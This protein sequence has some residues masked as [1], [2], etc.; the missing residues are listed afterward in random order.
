ME[1]LGVIAVLVVIATPVMLIILLS[2]VGSIR[3]ELQLLKSTVTGAGARR[4]EQRDRSARAAHLGEWTAAP[5]AEDHVTPE[6]LIAPKTSLLPPPLPGGASTAMEIAMGTSLPVDSGLPSRH[7]RPRSTASRATPLTK[8]PKGAAQAQDELESLIGKTWL[9]R[10]GAVVLVLGLGFLYRWSE[11]NGILPPEARVLMGTV[12]GLA[13]WGL[14]TRFAKKS[15]YAPLTQGFLGGGSAVLFLSAFAADAQFQLIPSPVA[16]GVMVGI[17][18]VT[19]MFALRQSAVPLAVLAQIGGYLTPL[20]CGDPDAGPHQLFGYLLILNAGLLFAA[21]SRKW[22]L[23]ERLAWIG[24]ALLF[25]LA[26]VQGLDP[27]TA[28]GWATA[29][30]A[31]FHGFLIVPNWRR[32]EAFGVHQLTALGVNAASWLVICWQAL[33]KE[34]LLGLT[35]FAFG[36]AHVAFAQAWRNRISDHQNGRDVITGVGSLL[37]FAAVPIMI[38]AHGLTIGWALQGAVLVIGAG[39]TNHGFLAAAGSIAFAAAAVRIAAVHIPLAGGVGFLS[40]FPERGD[41]FLNP[42][43]LTSLSVM[44]AAGIA[45]SA[46]GRFRA[47]LILGTMLGTLAITAVET[48][49]GVARMRGV[50]DGTTIATGSVLWSA[51]ASVG[52]LGAVMLGRRMRHLVS[53]ATAF[54]LGLAA[55]ALLVTNMHILQDAPGLLFLNPHFLLMASVPVL[56]AVASGGIR[57]SGVLGAQEENRAR[58]SLALVALTLPLGLLSVEVAGF[59]EREQGRQFVNAALSVTWTAYAAILLGSG[60]LRKMAALRRAGWT[61]SP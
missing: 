14:G 20:L 5:S 13:L 23:V 38:G 34:E 16:F 33:G 27:W 35:T 46:G 4:R 59:F 39:R 50:V 15:H 8:T 18:A 26:Y 56:F 40:M 48:G 24:T 7:P 55:L 54:P 47:P 25:G 9:V 19:V 41:L 11:E 12:A 42:D 44:A 1:T 61:V 32:R 31:L 3:R 49:I 37:M 57:G 51:Y 43:Y 6:D 60:M 2:Q 53:L 52:M 45:A 21:T 58:R 22:V 28:C 36:L 10:I 30:V 29:F 17:T